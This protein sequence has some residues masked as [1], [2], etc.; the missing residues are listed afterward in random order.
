MLKFQKS[1]DP[2]DLAE[3]GISKDQ[4]NAYVAQQKAKPVGKSGEFQKSEIEQFKAYN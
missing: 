2:K 4:Y 3:V 1:G